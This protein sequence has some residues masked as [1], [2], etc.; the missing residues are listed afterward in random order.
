MLGHKLYQLALH[1][2]HEVFGSMRQDCQEFARL[3]L[4]DENKIFGKVDV[5]SDLAVR[6]VIAESKPDVVVNCAGLV[7]PRVR[8]E[9]EAI[10]INSLFPHKLAQLCSQVGSRLIQ[11]STDCVFSGASGNYYEESIPDP[12]DLYGL[13]KLLGEVKYA[14]HLTIR[15]SIIGRELGTKR[16]LLEWFLRQ[17]GQVRGFTRAIFSGLSTREFSKII[18]QLA[19]TNATGLLHVGTQPISKFNLL[20]LVKTE[21]RLSQL[22]VIPYDGETTDRSLAVRKMTA[23]GVRVPPMQVMIHDMASENRFYDRVNETWPKEISA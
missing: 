20:Q 8:S 7:K 15:T 12:V 23:M 14:N 2:G 3:N 9:L 4:F 5:R 18:L 6:A 19:K 22:S 17:R 1:Y 13:T 11:V 21:F 10:E 16:N